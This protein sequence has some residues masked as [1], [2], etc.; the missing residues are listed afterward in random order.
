MFLTLNAFALP[1][2]GGALLLAAAAFAAGLSVGALI[3][4]VAASRGSDRAP[5]SRRGHRHLCPS[6]AAAIRPR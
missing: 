2:R 1:R 4:P 6:C 3:A 5:R